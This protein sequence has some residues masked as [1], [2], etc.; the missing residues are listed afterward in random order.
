VRRRLTHVVVGAEG[1]T[2]RS[3]MV[4][5]ERIDQTTR[6]VVRLSCTLAE[7]A[8]LPEFYATRYVPASAP[9]AQPAIEAWQVDMSRGAA[10]EGYYG[11]YSPYVTWPGGEV[12][13]TEERVPPGHL[14]FHRGTIVEAAGGDELGTVAE[15]VLDPRDDTITHFVLRLGLLAGAREVA[16]PVSIVA[17]ASPETVRLK[18]SRDAVERLPAI[19]ARRHY[20]WASG[21]TGEVELVTL[22]FRTLEQA[23]Q[24]LTAVKVRA[25]A[26][27]LP[28]FDAAVL[29]KSPRG[30][31]SSRQQHDVSG[32]RGAVM[33]A[34]AG[35]AVSLL[36]GP[37]GP[38][39]GAVAGGAIGGLTAQ[40]VDRGVPDRYLK[41]LGHALQP[42]SSALIVLI[43]PG[44]ADAVVRCLEP[45]GG[46]VLRQLLTDE[47]IR[48]LTTRPG[49]AQERP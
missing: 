37:I 2:P 4:P 26:G 28:K 34:I 3:L 49:E 44:S 1:E 13:V 24:A 6:D 25:A 15:F 45:L 19:S 31:V 18:L 14:S 39:V 40:A 7:A 12:P 27:E 42:G 16:L 21:S 11:Y 35:G 20:Q 9:E 41:D 17:S 36:A 43:P 5:V 22:V 33:G 8:D 46:T 23:G 30:R 38:V 48:A 10:Y 47:M 29:T 32:G